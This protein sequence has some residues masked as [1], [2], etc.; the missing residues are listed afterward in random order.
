MWMAEVSDSNIPIT[1]SLMND[2]TAFNGALYQR[3]IIPTD[4]DSINSLKRSSSR[5]LFKEGTSRYGLANYGLNCQL[6][7]SKYLGIFS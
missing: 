3:F 2:G 5:R 4:T 6:G 7:K 1:Y